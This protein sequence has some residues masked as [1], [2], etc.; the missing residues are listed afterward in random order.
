MV[1]LGQ[2]GVFDTFWFWTVEYARAYVSQVSVEQA[3]RQFTIGAVPVFQAAPGLWILAAGGLLALALDG[4]ARRRARVLAP[5]T[6]GSLLAIC[7]G[8]FFRPHYFV[9]LLPAAA[10]LVGVAVHALAAAVGR[11]RPSWQTPVA[12][13]LTLLAGVHSVYTQREL[14]FQQTPLQVMR[15]TY[16]HNPFPESPLLAE[17]IQD[18]TAPEDRIAVIGSEPQIYFYARRRSATGFIYTYALMEDHPFAERMQE[19]M[20]AEI[21]GS[22]PR[23]VLFVRHPLSWLPRATSSPR[24]FRWFQEYR[25]R[26][27]L[28]AVADL[29]AETPT[30][31]RGAALRGLRPPPLAVYVYATR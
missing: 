30:I 20:I 18:L 5:W 19:Q 8:F 31:H 25:Q 21:E 4:R 6:V 22:D 13:S 28:V 27:R 2:L 3:L 11:R 23:V 7:P 10:M 14:L 1:L 15:S 29:R 16:G 26:L 24:I 17:L 9:L 12:F